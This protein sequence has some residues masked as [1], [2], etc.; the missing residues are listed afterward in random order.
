[1]VADDDLDPLAAGVFHLVHGL[2]A[3]VQRDDQ[4]EPAVGGPVD[5]LVGHAVA[6]VIAVGDVEVHLVGEALD[7]R[8][9]QGHGGGPVHVV[10]AVDQDFLAAGYGLVQPLHGRVHV[11]HQEGV[12]QGVQARAEE[13][14]RLVEGLDAALDQ[15]F[16]QH[17]VDAQLRGK[18]PD[19]RGVGR[20]LG[21]PFAFFRHIIQR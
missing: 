21:D 13:A 12:V 2:D 6:F 4:G 16:G 19:L 18:A 15:Q 14:A 1:M 10:V 17:A 5:A 7:E 8:V 9:H 3:A 11:F 20:F